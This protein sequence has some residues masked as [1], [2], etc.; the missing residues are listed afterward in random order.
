M[1]MKTLFKSI[2]LMLVAVLSAF[3]PQNAAAQSKTAE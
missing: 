3:L 1:K 2:S